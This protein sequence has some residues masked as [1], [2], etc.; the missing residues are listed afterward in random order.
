MPDYDRSITPRIVHL[1]VGGFARAHL[2][3]YADDLL[4][5]GWPAMI[6]GVSLRSDRAEQQLRPQDGW[7]TV[8][9]R[10]PGGERPLRLVGSLASVETGAEAAIE[11]IAAPATEL[12]TLTVTE[13]GYAIGAAPTVVA[14]GLAQR[15]RR[16]PPPV[17]ASLD[18]VSH[19]GQV[20]RQ[21]VV[22][23]AGAIDRD[24]ARWVETEVRF[25]C[26][27]VDRIVPAI[28]SADLHALAQRLAL[29]DEAA[30]VA[31]HHRSWFIEAV[32]GLPPLTDVGVQ[33]VGD[34]GPYQRRK[35]WLLNGP[36]SALAYGGLLA[37]CDTIATAVEHPAVAAF[38]ARLVDDVLAV[39]DLPAAAVP[40]AFVASSLRR[41]ANP[42]LGHTCRQVGADGSQKLA[43]RILPVVAARQASGLPTGRLALVVAIWLAAGSG[44]PVGGVALPAVDDPME[45]DLRRLAADGD[46]RALAAAGVGGHGDAAFID[47]VVG[48][49]RRVRDDG[50]DVLRDDR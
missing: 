31:E 9:E 7:Y 43:Q 42:A 17:V 48:T 36:H 1:G 16:H 4:R 49:L 39:A 20:L 33:V 30:V 21:S 13:K 23:A 6:R 26:S 34:V 2:G 3:T 41:F 37:G 47:E 18:N 10:E 15:D 11:A 32:D 28:T 45:D 35:L 5:A 19:N 44:L 14:R 29:R 12:V 24:L 22:E 40:A 8:A 50:I 25:P 27:V 38:V 46:L